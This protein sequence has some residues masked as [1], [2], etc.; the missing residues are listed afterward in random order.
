MAKEN[1]EGTTA[2]Q[3]ALAWGFVEI[4]LMLGVFKP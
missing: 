2:L 3:L 4:P 1:Q